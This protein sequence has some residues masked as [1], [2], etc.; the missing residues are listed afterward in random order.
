MDAILENIATKT[1]IALPPKPL[2]KEVVPRSENLLERSRLVHGFL[3]NV[4]ANDP[5]AEETKTL[6][7]I[8]TTGELVSPSLRPLDD[9]EKIRF[10]MDAPFDKNRVTFH[11]W[12]GDEEDGKSY[13]S[14]AFFAAPTSILGGSVPAEDPA[15]PGRVVSAYGKE[16]VRLPIEKGLLFISTNRAIQ[17]REK[18]EAL[19]QKAGQTYIEYMNKHV[20]I[21]PDNIFD[22]KKMLWSAISARIEPAMGVTTKIASS[23]EQMDSARGTNFTDMLNQRLPAPARELGLSGIKEGST[24]SLELIDDLKQSWQSEIE[25]LKKVEKNIDR[26][27]YNIEN[28]RKEASSLQ[29]IQNLINEIQPDNSD[30]PL[31]SQYGEKRR[32]LLKK[33]EVM[34]EKKYPD[35]P[36]ETRSYGR[37]RY[38]RTPYRG[39]DGKLHFDESI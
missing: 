33:F 13:I 25:W 7:G 11:V 20:V 2:I 38:E 17:H 1:V 8:L 23:R 4:D 26:D 36:L 32:Q 30:V 18:F 29:N 9:K 5:Y 37:P 28:L 35:A 3:G 14:K 24:V 39:A 12:K 15:W 34:L 22:D 19:A 10:S 16:G 21:L 31:A 6:N 27:P